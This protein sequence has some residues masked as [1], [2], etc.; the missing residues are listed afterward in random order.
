MRE[1]VSLYRHML[2]TSL[3]LS[4]PDVL[5]WNWRPWYDCFMDKFVL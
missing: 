2:W 4:T 1:N 3:V 5:K